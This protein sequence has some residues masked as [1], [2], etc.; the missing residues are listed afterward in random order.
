MKSLH[1]FYEVF[2]QQ[3]AQTNLRVGTPS[4]SIAVLHISG[5]GVELVQKRT[6]DHALSKLM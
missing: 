6:A 3:A 1:E 5:G 4:A 2:A